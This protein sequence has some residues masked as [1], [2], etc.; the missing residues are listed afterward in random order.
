MSGSTLSTKPKGIARG[1]NTIN[2]MTDPLETA[3]E[4]MDSCLVF[5]PEKVP[6]AFINFYFK[7]TMI[8]K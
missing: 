7:A 2:N 5:G 6:H 1:P 8:A 3:V 4:K